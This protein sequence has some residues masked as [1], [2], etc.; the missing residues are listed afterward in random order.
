MLALNRSLLNTEY[1]R[2][3][4]KKATAANILKTFCPF[5]ELRSKDPPP[6]PNHTYHAPGESRPHLPTICLL[7]I[8]MIVQNCVHMLA[9]S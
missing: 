6:P 5:V 2:I 9:D 1:I 8:A 4:V 7:F 3:N